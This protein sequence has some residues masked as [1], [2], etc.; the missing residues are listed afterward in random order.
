MD[1]VPLDIPRSPWRTYKEWISV[2]HFLGQN[3]RK[4][5]NRAWQTYEEARR[6]AVEM[7]ILDREEWLASSRL[8]RIPVDI[9][10]NPNVVY[11]GKGWKGWPAFLGRAVRGGSSIVEDVIA[12]ELSHFTVVDHNT[13]S[14]AIGGG[15]RKR[16]DI[17]LSD[18]ALIVEYDGAHWHKKSLAGC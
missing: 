18:L 7:S 17:V 12:H 2:P 11:R 16:V 10:M 5:K 4:S 3:E 14:I 9:P 1:L 15:A 8:G 6:W 13:R